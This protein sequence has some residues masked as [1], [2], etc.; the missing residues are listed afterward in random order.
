MLRG[1]LSTVGALVIV[2]SLLVMLPTIILPN[3]FLHQIVPVLAPLHQ[4]IACDD[5]ETI[6]YDLRQDQDGVFETHFLCVNAGGVERNVDDVLRRPG[7]IAAGTLFLG[8]LIILGP[9]IFA[10]RQTLSGAYGAEAQNALRMS[11]DQTRQGFAEMKANSTAQT[12]V[13]TEPDDS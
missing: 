9:M 2:G 1:L 4:F 11:I 7:Y 5:G 13:E 3:T 12:G 8:V 10:I 6:R